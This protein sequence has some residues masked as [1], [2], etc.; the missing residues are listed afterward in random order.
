MRSITPGLVAVF[1]TLLSVASGVPHELRSANIHRRAA[2]ISE[3]YDYVIVG[4]GTAG[5][6]IADRLTA[7]GECKSFQTT[8]SEQEFR[9]ANTAS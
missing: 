3:E 8:S 5:L 9:G 2:D 1:S 6:T 4:A 7:D